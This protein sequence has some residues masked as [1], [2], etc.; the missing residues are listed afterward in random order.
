MTLCA[1]V[2]AASTLTLGMPDKLIALILTGSL[3]LW[4]L[5][6]DGLC[7]LPSSIHSA[8]YL[9]QNG[10]HRLLL[11]N[12]KGTTRQCRIHPDSRVWGTWV[13][14]F[15]RWPSRMLVL[16]PGNTDIDAL[17]RLRVALRYHKGE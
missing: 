16:H 7:R 12:R 6:R 10:Q 1:V 2:L 5:L 9:F 4:Y 13:I 3:P 8:Q 17:R 14:L 15:T 11:V